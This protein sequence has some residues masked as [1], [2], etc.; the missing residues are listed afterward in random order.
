[1]MGIT[2]QAL[3]NLD[4]DLRE[5]YRD[6]KFKIVLEDQPKQLIPAS[7]IKEAQDRW[8]D[9]PPE[10]VPMCSIGVDV[11]Q[12]GKDDN[13]LAARHD[14]WYAPLV[15]VPGRETQ[16][17]TDLLGPIMAMRRDNAKIILDV[18]GGYG[19]DTYKSLIDNT[20][21]VTPHKGAK[22]STK[23]S[24][25]GLYGFTN[26][27]AEVYY[28]F[29]EALNPARPGGSRIALPPDTTLFADLTAIL[30]TVEKSAN[31]L[32]VKLEPKEKLCSRIGR[33][34]DHG[35]AV[36]NG[37]SGGDKIENS[38]GIWEKNKRGGT[39][40]KQTKAIMSNRR[41]RR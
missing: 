34:P 29:R 22:G 36:V 37:W 19:S 4:D 11:A 41:A 14:G 30:F 18:G 6:G 23:K 13:I 40:S 10:G 8:M 5:A 15:K 39:M 32:V 27:R 33:S 24:E 38:Y 31:G 9:Q 26:Y 17:G 25:C 20:I 16:L 1:M 7:W 3:D 12:G 35:D 21:P 2:K 28:R